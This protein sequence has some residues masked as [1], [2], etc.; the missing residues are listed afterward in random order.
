M[1]L[2]SV[3]YSCHDTNYTYYDGETLQ[4]FKLERHKQEKHAC[5]VE[6]TEWRE[7]GIEPDAICFDI[8]I[9]DFEHAKRNI[10]NTFPLLSIICNAYNTFNE[11]TKNLLEQLFKGS[12]NYFKATEDLKRLFGATIEEVWIIGHHY[13]HSLSGWMLCKDPDVSIVIDG[14]GD[15]DRSIS[16]YNKDSLI[17]SEDFENSIGMA[18]LVAAYKCGIQASHP[19]DVSGKLMG[20]Q[21]YGNVCENPVSNK[22]IAA[23]THYS[24]GQRVMKVFEKYA[25]PDDVIY[26]SGGVGQNVLWNTELRN[27]Y[28]NIVIAPHC[29]DDGLSLGGIEFLRRQYDLD[30]FTLENFPYIQSDI[31][32]PEPSNETI[33]RTAEL[34]ADG[35]IVAWY[36]GNGEIGPRA[37]GNRSILM[38]PRIENGRDI[39]NKI[40]KREYYRPFGASVLAEHCDTKDDYMLFVT[41]QYSQYPAI[42]HIDGT[43]RLQTVSK[44]GS[45]RRLLEEFYSITKCPVLL[46]TSLNIA[47]KPIAAYPDNARELFNNTGI[48][49]LVIGDELVCKDF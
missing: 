25:S 33:R 30:P 41:K 42:T 15:K 11:E 8:T 3:A 14:V 2:L 13:S 32:V 5:A 46:N 1:K 27:K 35:K 10:L 47:G 43:C 16:I 9:T 18:Y 23:S 17:Y 34:L 4:Y 44:E 21:S 26:Y 39:I 12:I 24:L 48:D 36:Q 45:F 19:M 7:W 31:S 49:V 38:D 22:D 40:K 20:F 37:L 6:P 29:A 28:P